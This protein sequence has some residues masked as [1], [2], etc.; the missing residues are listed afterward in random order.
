MYKPKPPKLVTIAIITT[1]TIV[2][3]VFF[4]LYQVLTKKPDIEVPDVLLQEINPN[5]DV[6]TL[7]QLQDR[8]FFEEGQVSPIAQPA[9]QTDLNTQPPPRIQ[10]VDGETEETETED[11]G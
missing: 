2:F 8:L 9:I 10:E 1:I 3:W 4:G 11:G 6:T 7:N 5:L